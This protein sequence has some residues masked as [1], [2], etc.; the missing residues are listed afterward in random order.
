MADHRRERQPPELYGKLTG[1]R[2]DLDSH[3]QLDIP[4]TAPGGDAGT[5][6]PPKP[7]DPPRR[8]PCA[9]TGA[10]GRFVRNRRRLGLR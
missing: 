6:P 8:R 1:H 9:R 10:R 4:A 7:D 5:A 2:T 3:E